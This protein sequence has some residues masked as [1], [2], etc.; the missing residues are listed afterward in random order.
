MKQEDALKVLIQT[1]QIAVERGGFKLADA[2]V[3]GEAVE[4]FMQKQEAPVEEVPKKEK[5]K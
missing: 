5:K 1:A 3:I 4:V 2:K